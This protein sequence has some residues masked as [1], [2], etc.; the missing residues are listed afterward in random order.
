M[1]KSNGLIQGGNTDQRAGWFYIKCDVDIFNLYNWFNSLGNKPW[2]PPMNGPHI[3]FIAG[4]HEERIIHKEEVA[5]YMLTPTL[6]LYEPTVWTD[7]RSFW[8]DA[9]APYVNVIRRKLGLPP[10]DR[11][12]LTLGNWKN[13]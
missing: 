9:Y 13:A 3:T 6:F 11:L 8:M 10:R 2:A 4:R 12:H 1:F 5:Q 7:G